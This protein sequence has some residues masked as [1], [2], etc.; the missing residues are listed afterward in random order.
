[1]AGYW[2]SYNPNTGEQGGSYISYDKFNEKYKSIF[3]TDIDL[4]ET[5]FGTGRG[6]VINGGY[7][8]CD[9]NSL[10]NCIYYT[11]KPFY[12]G[13]PYIDSEDVVYYDLQLH[14]NIVEGKL[15]YLYNNTTATFALEYEKK[16][17]NYYLKSLKVIK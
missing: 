7:N 15:Y 6:F 11:M 8:K 4:S 17:E 12:A 10:T 14:D 5:R 13:P 1:M 2:E 16:E 9:I 3:G